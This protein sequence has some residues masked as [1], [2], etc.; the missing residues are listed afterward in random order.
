M[1]RGALRVQQEMPIRVAAAAIVAWSLCLALPAQAQSPTLFSGSWSA[2][3]GIDTRA[4]DPQEDVGLL[5]NRLDLDLRHPLSDTMRTRMAAR[6]SHRASVGHESG[7]YV[8]A[9]RNDW[10]SYGMRYDPYADLREAYVQWDSSRWGNLT[11]GRDLALWGALELQSPLRI[12]NP[13]DFSM[14]L[15]GALGS[16]DD[17]TALADFMVKWQ[18]G[19]GLGTLEFVYLPFFTQHRFSPV[20]TDTAMIRPDLG[21]QVPSGLFP[22]LR[23]M[24]LRL[25]RSSSDALMYALKPPPATPLDGSLAGRWKHQIGNWDLNFDVIYNWDRL[26]KLTFD[27]DIATVLGKQAEAGFD[28]DKQL[29][30][31]GDPDYLAAAGRLNGSNKSMTDL[32]QAK[33]QRRL[34]LGLEWSGELKEGWMLRAD[35]AFS[36]KKVLLDASFQPVVSALT[37]V[38]MGIEY[39]REDWLVALVECSYQFAHDVPRGQTLFMMARHHVTAVGGLVLRLGEGQPWTVQLGGMVGVSLGDYAAAPKVSYQIDDS[40]RIGLGAIVAGGPPLS[41]G[42]LFKTDDQVL[43]D[44]RLAL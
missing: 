7:R 12:L 37:Q 19:V 34:T 15:L 30:L 13:S 35:A 31:L 25:D 14:G 17:T 40:W 26:P 27:K 32:V 18:R 38:G 5:Y 16:T 28:Q 11:V 33:W 2:L 3:L 24:D 23:R 10:P 29:A 8:P 1:H 36:P 42:G 21:P 9:F 44:V 20:A 39:S 22:L 4:E 43:A 41:A 6:F